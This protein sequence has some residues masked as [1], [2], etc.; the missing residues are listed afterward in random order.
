MRNIIYKKVKGY[1][2]LIAFMWYDLYI[3]HMKD[4]HKIES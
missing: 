1:I 2:Y 4:G 3:L